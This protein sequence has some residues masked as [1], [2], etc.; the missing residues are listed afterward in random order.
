MPAHRAVSLSDEHHVSELPEP[1]PH[2]NEARAS[3]TGVTGGVERPPK[4]CGASHGDQ[5]GS[6]IDR[7]GEAHGEAVGSNIRSSSSS[8]ALQVDCAP[9]G[10]SGGPRFGV[11]GT[12]V[13]ITT[14]DAVPTSR[15]NSDT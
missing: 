12:I 4:P 10:T 2:D 8:S 9:S 5:P 13:Q 1:E 6:P 7:L 11:I 14:V 15:R 3:L